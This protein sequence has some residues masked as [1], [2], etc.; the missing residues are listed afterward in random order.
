MIP[1][2]ICI[3]ISFF[4]TAQVHNTARITTLHASTW[5]TATRL[6]KSIKGM[7]SQP[8]CL[9]LVMSLS[10]IKSRPCTQ[11]TQAALT[12]GEIQLTDNF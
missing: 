5:Q 7:T 4:L 3:P 12:V 8:W 6:F 9:Q 10:I 11:S 1:A 2:D